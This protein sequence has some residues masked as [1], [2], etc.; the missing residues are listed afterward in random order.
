[1][2][3][4]VTYGLAFPFENSQKGDFLLLTETQFAQIRS[5]LIH[6]LLSYLFLV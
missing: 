4:G 3:E 6:L 1:M 5:D 2:A